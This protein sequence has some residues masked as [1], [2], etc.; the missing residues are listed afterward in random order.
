[1]NNEF[2]DLNITSGT[3][4]SFELINMVTGDLSNIDVYIEIN[5]ISE[6]SIILSKSLDFS[7]GSAQIKILNNNS[8]SQNLAN[9]NE[10]I[11]Q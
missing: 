6:P 4:Q 8:N 3:N 5:C 2:E 11:I 9:C 10:T 1:V 7:N